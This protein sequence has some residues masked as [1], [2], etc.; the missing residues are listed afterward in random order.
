MGSR[1]GVILGSS[2]TGARAELFE[3]VAGLGVVAVQRHAGAG[4]YVLPHRIDHAAT[5]RQLLD[6]GCEAALA[7]CSVGSLRAEIGVG[8]LVCPDDFIALQDRV[9]T[10]DDARAH[11]PPG[12]DQGWRRRLVEAAGGRLRD[13]GTY[14]QT[15]GPRFETPAEV[16]LIAGHAHLVG[17]TMASECVV[18][19]ELGL[20]YAAVCAVDNMANGLATEPLEVE[21]MEAVR[22]ANAGRLGELLEALAQE[23]T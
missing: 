16:R 5:L 19:G 4:G 23:L 21:E 17:M 3:R 22:D 13:G 6:A 8:E 9:T 15:T 7:I 1:L 10:F 18:A 11:R 14:W 2:A 20:P 12:F